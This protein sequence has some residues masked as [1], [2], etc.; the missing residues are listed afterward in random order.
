MPRAL[1][2]MQCNEAYVVQGVGVPGPGRIGKNT[3]RSKQQFFEVP[4][5]T[6][7]TAVPGAFLNHELVDG[8]AGEMRTGLKL[9]W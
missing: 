8:T 6:L 5:A 3:E 9:I 4:A 1:P 7:V 2:A